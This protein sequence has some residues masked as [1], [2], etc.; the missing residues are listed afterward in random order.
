M[1]GGRVRSAAKRSNTQR[2]SVPSD[3]FGCGLVDGGRPTMADCPLNVFD[4]CYEVGA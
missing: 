1:A 2:S 3:S 4:T